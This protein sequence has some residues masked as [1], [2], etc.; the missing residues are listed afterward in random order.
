MTPPVETSVASGVPPQGD[1]PDRPVAAFDFDG[2]LTV[3]DSFAAFLRWRTTRGRWMVALVRLVPSVLLYLT[4]RDRARLKAASVRVFLKG[5]SRARL[6]QEVDA[7]ALSQAGRLLRPDA[8]SA[9]TAHKARGDLT[10]IVTASP[11]DIVAPF[12]RKLGADALIATQLAWHEDRLTGDLAGPNCR[13]P[14]KVVRLRERFG[15]G[16]NISDAYGD[17]AGD[18]EMLAL[19]RIG[20]LRLFVGRP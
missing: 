5:V 20:H 9:W 3:R 7:F 10:V 16:L 2:T 12:A 13:G 11:E 18:R 1:D 17:T 4:S 6:A 14:E 19:A 8:L 15:D